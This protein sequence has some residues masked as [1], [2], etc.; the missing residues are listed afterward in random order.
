MTVKNIIFDWDGTLVRTLDLWLLGYQ[1]ALGSR[2]YNFD[3]QT[4]VKEFF[5]N[6]HEVP[7]RHPQI[8]F[9]AVFE[10][11]RNHVFDSLISVELY[12]DVAETLQTLKENRKTLTLVTSSSRSLLNRALHGHGLEGYFESIVAGDD[13]FGHKPSALPFEETLGRIRA[14]AHETLII[15]D[16]HVDIQA[17]KTSGCHTCWFAPEANTIFHDFAH[18]KSLSPDHEI[19]GIRELVGIA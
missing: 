7:A 6:H 15:G 1:T 12:E 11:T 14:D 3:P 16:S 18:V 19:T 9:A 2:G 5:Y 4:I 13:G 8:D 17:G 10:E